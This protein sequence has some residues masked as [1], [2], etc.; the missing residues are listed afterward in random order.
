M[1]SS[2]N[3]LP[4]GEK[5]GGRRHFQPTLPS[6]SLTT[7]IYCSHFRVEYCRV[8]SNDAAEQ[9]WGSDL[10]IVCAQKILLKMPPRRR[11]WEGLLLFLLY[12]LLPTSAYA[13]PYITGLKV[14]AQQSRHANRGN[15]CHFPHAR[16]GRHFVWVVR[17][18][19]DTV[20]ASS[21]P[22][23]C[24]VAIWAFCTLGLAPAVSSHLNRCYVQRFLRSGVL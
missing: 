22:Q 15:Q 10:K 11:R 20:H 2:A 17:G 16:F 13:P 6:Q 21:W 3:P 4:K 9:P 14:R 23:V 12:V 5:R 24:L 1:A 7:T 18:G 8:H 19:G